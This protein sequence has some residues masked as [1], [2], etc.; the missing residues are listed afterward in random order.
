MKTLG[1]CAGLLGTSSPSLGLQVEQIYSSG[2]TLPSLCHPMAQSAWTHLV[3]KKT[4]NEVQDVLE[5]FKMLFDIDVGC[6]SVFYSGQDVVLLRTELNNVN[7]NV[8][9]VLRPTMDR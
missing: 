1:G 8:G 6:P 9:E 5:E 2:P 7:G 4:E 3:R